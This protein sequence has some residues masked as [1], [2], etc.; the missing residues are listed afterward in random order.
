MNRRKNLK[1]LFW[2]SCTWSTLVSGA[3][4]AAGSR[5]GAP[6]LKSKSVNTQQ[7][8]TQETKAQ[9]NIRFPDDP[10]VIDVTKAPYGADRSG[11]ADA[12]EAIRRAIADHIGSRAFIYFP[13]GTYKVSG[14]LWWKGKSWKGNEQGWWARLVFRGQSRE[15]VVI[16]LVDN[17]PGF[18]QQSSPLGVIV[19]ASESPFPDGGNNQGFNNSVRNM[20]IDTGSGNPGAVGIDYV[21]SNQGAIKD[22]T[23]LS[24]DGKG[25]AGI[26]M[27]RAYP[28]PGLIK[29][30]EIQGFDYGIKWTV[31]DYS[32]TL[33]HIALKNQNRAAIF[34]STGQAHIRN[35]TSVNQVPVLESRSAQGKGGGFNMIIGGSF[36]GGSPAN[37][38]IV[39]AGDLLLRDLTIV[40]YGTA[41]EDK[42]SVGKGLPMS[43]S[44]TKIGEY[45]NREVKSLFPSPN[46]TLRLPIEETPNHIDADPATWANIA[47]FGAVG[48]GKTDCTKA[49]QQALNSGKATLWLPGKAS[50]LVSNTLVVP[51]SVRH[52]TGPHAIVMGKGESFKNASSPRP[53]FK[54][55]EN[56][57][58]PLIFEHIETLGD[59]GAIAL[60]QACQRTV[61]W[62]HGSLGGGWGD[63][64]TPCYINS[65]TGGKLFIEDCIGSRYQVT[66]PQQ[67]WARQLNTEYG[68]SPLVEISG[69]G[70]KMWILGWK[71]ENSEGQQI[72]K[73]ANGAEVES[74]GPYCYMLHSS[75]T[76]PLIQNDEGR[77]STSFRQA[78]QAGYRLAIRE[79]R[80]HMMKQA[81]DLWGN[82]TLYVGYR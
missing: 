69:P 13:N 21:V 32:M 82:V 29:N 4:N 24:G 7:T 11:K 47:D 81:K 65:A 17:A 57:G 52:V 8:K 50:Y 27:E 42:S 61:V 53:I 49:I 19:T 51:G 64:K 12:T 70:A 10:G 37:S 60:D 23:I 80:D 43:G 5:V 1:W 2:L 58:N 36:S 16:K 76:V 55:S 63:G 14:P 34:N 18:D 78:G 20:T 62:Q 3:C 6:Q 46:H 33:E 77:L 44:P 22:V 79:T 39:S 41:I 40:G 38:A 28:G 48:D 54:V 75:D 59:D 35:L 74:F 15:G 30:V 72:L 73:V 56:S 71:T 67:V 9:E 45:T 68:S 66:G 26:R 25:Y 31:M